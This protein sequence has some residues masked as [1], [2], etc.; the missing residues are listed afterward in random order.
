MQVEKK[1]KH[2]PIE[3][4]V[5]SHNSVCLVWAD[6]LKEIASS[7]VP[8]IYKEVHELDDEKL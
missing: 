1:T 6:Q 2:L 3:F 4:I 5:T 7:A 8:S